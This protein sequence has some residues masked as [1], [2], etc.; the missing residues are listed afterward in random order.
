MR[1]NQKAGRQGEKRNQRVEERKQ[2][3]IEYEGLDAQG[4]TSKE[5][6]GSICQSIFHQ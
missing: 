4:A 6:S 1:G 2:G 5:T 3:N